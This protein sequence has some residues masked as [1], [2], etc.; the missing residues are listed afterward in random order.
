MC[1]SNKDATSDILKDPI[2][3][4]AGQTKSKPPTRHAIALG[5][6]ANGNADATIGNDTGLCEPAPRNNHHELLQS[7]KN[8]YDDEDVVEL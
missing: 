4:T 3:G 1:V 5:S 2:H 8:H 6:L 7:V